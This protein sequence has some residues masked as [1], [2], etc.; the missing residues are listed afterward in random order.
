MYLI[1]M[2]NRHNSKCII[3][4]GGGGGLLGITHTSRVIYNK[5]TPKVVFDEMFVACRRPVHYPVRARIHTALPGWRLPIWTRN[6]HRCAV[7]SHHTAESSFALV[8]IRKCSSLTIYIIR[9]VANVKMFK[10]NLIEWKMW[11]WSRTVGNCSEYVKTN[12]I[13]YYVLVDAL[14]E[15]ALL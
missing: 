5:I 7:I 10:Y 4:P 13:K 2:W 14:A 11:S 15:S 8:Q 3:T 6:T 1:F 9:H 12:Q